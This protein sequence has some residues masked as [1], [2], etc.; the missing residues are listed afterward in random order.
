LARGRY[1]G[2]LA[3]HRSASTHR[4][5]GTADRDDGVVRIHGSDDAPIKLVTFETLG[6]EWEA[7]LHFRTEPAAEAASDST[8]A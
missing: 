5:E 2:I 6:P 8:T 7:L 4:F 1:G 3:R